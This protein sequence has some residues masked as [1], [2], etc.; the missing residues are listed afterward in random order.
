MVADTDRDK[1]W[2]LAQKES[3]KQDKKQLILIHIG[4][5][6]LYYTTFTFT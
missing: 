2:E 1:M 5:R 3:N 4:L 6:K